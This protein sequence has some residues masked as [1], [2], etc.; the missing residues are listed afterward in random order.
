MSNHWIKKAESV[1][2]N[3][4]I[5]SVRYMTQEEA[6]NCG[7]YRKSIVIE[8]DD[9]TLFYP[10]SDDEGNDAGAIHYVKQ[11]DENYILPTI[12]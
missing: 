2:L 9:G 8:L 4:K 10:S 7:F 12:N 5:V 6:D 11:N 3:R 1:L